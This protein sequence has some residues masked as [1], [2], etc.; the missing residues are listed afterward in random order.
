MEQPQYNM[1]HRDR[2]EAEYHR[3]YENPGLGTTIWSPL[4]SGVLT[5]K[6]NDG[7]PAGSR[8]SLPDFTWLQER[9][10]DDRGRA[11]LARTR[12]LADLAREIGVSL[13]QLAIAWCLTNP[14]VSTVIL[15]ASNEDQLAENLLALEWVER[16][17]EE[18]QERIEGILQ[19]RPELPEQF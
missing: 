4:A 2:V 15:G 16:I 18:L 19:N 3:L 10:E 14:N 13:T 1:L 11:N 12:Q 6:Y 9:I 5:G 8:M 7:V 17:D